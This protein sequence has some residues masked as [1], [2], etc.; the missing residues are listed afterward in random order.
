MKP[1]ILINLCLA[2]LFS[3]ISFAQSNVPDKDKTSIFNS[4]GFK[5][6]LGT[7]Q[8]KCSFGA[9]SLYQDLNGDKRPDA[10]V[11]DGGTACYPKIGV[12]FYIVTQ[13]ANKTWRTIFHSAGEPK[14]LKTKG[15]NGWPDIEV[16]D[17]TKCHSIFRWDGKNYNKHRHEYNNKECTLAMPI[18]TQTEEKKTAPPKIDEKKTTP[19]KV[20]DKKVV[21]TKTETKKAKPAKKAPPINDPEELEQSIEE[22][23]EKVQES[24]VAQTPV[25][26]QPKVVQPSENDIKMYKAF[27]GFE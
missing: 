4:A 26:A 23:A 21:T 27:E 16:I 6:R 11:K 13:Q 5:N 2:L 18:Q 1:F 19:P 14:L 10:I 12:G 15:L 3:Q 22:E 17:S 8:S 7:W 25:E 20:E 24:Q 9:I